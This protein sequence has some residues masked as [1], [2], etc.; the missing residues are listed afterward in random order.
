MANASSN[1]TNMPINQ[2][3]PDDMMPPAPHHAP[4]PARR[5]H[6]DWAART[7]R[8]EWFIVMLGCALLLIAVSLFL[9]FSSSDDNSGAEADLVDTSKYQAVFLN[10]GSTSS[11][12]GYN[13]YFGHIRVLNDKYVVLQDVYYLVP[14]SSQNASSTIAKLSCLQALPSDQLIIDRNQVAIWQNIKDDGTVTKAIQG[15]IQQNPDTSKCPQPM[16]TT[17]PSSTSASTTS[18]TQTP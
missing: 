8:I 16:T 18:S 15:Y 6:I 3:V 10:G 17:S 2:P 13:S 4:H 11:K 9:G 12:T 7:I 1:K 5:K 14:G